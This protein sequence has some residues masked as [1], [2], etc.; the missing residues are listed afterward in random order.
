MSELSSFLAT[1]HGS[2]QG[3]FFRAFVERHARALGLTGYVNNLPGGRTLEVRAEGE[4]AHLEEL[5]KRL[6][7]GPPFAR[8]ERVDVEWSEYSGDFRRFQ[9]RH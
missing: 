9:A 1:V 5:L 6:H 4:Q 3:V 8:V 2:V 7:G